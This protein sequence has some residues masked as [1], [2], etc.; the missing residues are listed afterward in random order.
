[1]RNDLHTTADRLFS[2]ALVAAS[3]LWFSMASQSAGCG[4]VYSEDSVKA[5]FVLRFT[6]YVTWPA[7]AAT[8]PFRIVV[9]DDEVMASRLQVLVENRSFARRPFD[10]RTIRSLAEAR[11]AHVLYIGTRRGATL[12]PLPRSVRDRGVL[13]IT[14]APN[15]LEAGAVV[16]FLT[17]DQRVRFEV[18]MEAARSAGL[19]IGSEMLSAAIRVQSAQPAAKEGQR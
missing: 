9:L 3:A 1:V 12:P 19:G 6:G 8:G 10:V 17:I 7:T 11:G 16:N 14:S 5:A 18:S 4:D 13:T 2:R 15:G